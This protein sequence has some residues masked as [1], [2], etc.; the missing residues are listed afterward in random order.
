MEERLE[1]PYGL[2]AG[3]VTASHSS[4]KSQAEVQ[5]CPQERELE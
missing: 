2:A 3:P 4:R 5:T 1:K